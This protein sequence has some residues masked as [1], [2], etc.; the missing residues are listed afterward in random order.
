MSHPVGDSPTKEGPMSELPSEHL[1][2]PF[3]IN[4]QRALSLVSAYAGVPLVIG[5]EVLP[6][7]QRHT[8]QFCAAIRVRGSSDVRPRAHAPRP[9]CKWSPRSRDRVYVRL[10]SSRDGVPHTTIVL[11]ILLA[12]K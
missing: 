11:S 12:Y 1:R 9:S 6:L 10:A 4:D 2:L 8:C 3:E 7:I 5:P